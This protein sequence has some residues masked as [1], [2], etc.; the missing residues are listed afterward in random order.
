MR[1]PAD[2]AGSAALTRRARAWAFAVLLLASRPGRADSE[3]VV[4]GTHDAAL[5]S[6][7]SVAVSPRGLSVFELPGPLMGV[8]DIEAARREISVPGTVAVVWLCDDESGAHALCFC[9]RDG[10]LAVRPLSVT[11]PLAPP[12]AAAVALSVK[13]LLGSPPP[14]PAPTRSPPPTT[15]PSPTP[16]PHLSP[17]RPAPPTLAVELAAGA[18]L[19]SPPSQHVGLRLGLKG[20]FTPEALGRALGVGVGLAAGPSLASGGAAPAGRTV[21][22]VAIELGA[23]GRLPLAPLWLE[24]ELGP[25]VHV[26]SVD[27]GPPA[28]R[29]PELALDALGGAVLP[30]GRALVGFRAGGFYVLTS[31]SAAAGAVAPAALPRWNGEAMLTVG[32]ALR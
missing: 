3:R 25:S 22:D 17:G 32:L 10:I 2:I 18:R 8:A 14:P 11:T 19:Q 24:L 20:V 6:A 28:A 30:F 26:L 7:L 21:N 15:S 13:M 27:A 4:L 29:R 23:H 16:A 9:G 5:A 1:P 12:D 31:P